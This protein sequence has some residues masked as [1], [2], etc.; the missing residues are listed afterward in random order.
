[1]SWIQDAIENRLR[2][3]GA[4]LASHLFHKSAP[5]L[6]RGN[7]IGLDNPTDRNHDLRSQ[8]QHKKIVRQTVMSTIL[9][10]AR[11]IFERM[12]KSDM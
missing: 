11:K 4:W 6:P 7:I 1:M 10:A 8:L 2:E 9:G 3:W 12:G 5:F